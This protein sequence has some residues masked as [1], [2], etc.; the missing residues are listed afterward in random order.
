MARIY[1]DYYK[2]IKSDNGSIV[3]IAIKYDDTFN[4][5]YDVVDRFAKEEPNKLALVHRSAE[6]EDRRFTFGEIKE[7][8]D[9]AANMLKE[10]GVKRGDSVM[11]LLKRR[12]EYWISIIAIHKLGA[13]AIPT[14]HMV[15][16]E[17]IRQRVTLAGAKVVICVNSD[18]ICSKV[19]EALDGINSI[20]LV[21]GDKYKD[22]MSFDEL[23]DEAS[24]KFERV[25]T[26]VDDDMLYYFTSGTS[27]EPKAVI[28][29]FSY[30]IAHIF[31]AKNWHGVEED[32]LHLTVADSGWAKSAWGKLYGQWFMGAAIMVYDY[33]QFYAG[34]MLRLLE[35]EKIRTFCAPPTIYKY[36][37]LEDFSKYNLNNLRYVT[38]AGEPMPKEIAKKFTEL[39]GLTIR[40]GFGQT[41][42]ALQ[43]CTQVGSEQIMGTIGCASP[44]Y[45][46]KLVDEDNNPVPVGEEG[47]IVIVPKDDKRPI[48]IF[49]G[50]LG[51]K[52]LYKEIW[53]GGIYHTKDKAIIDDTGHFYF[54][55]RN[56]D[57]IKSSGYRIG[58][59]EVEDIL[60]RHPAVFECAVTAYPSKNRGAV[61]KASI[62]LNKE[63]SDDGKLSKDIQEFVKNRVA[64]YKYPRIIKF[65][66]ELPRTSTGK[67]SRAKI[68][69]A[70]YQNNR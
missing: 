17:D 64:I 41:E 66:D 21:V 61:V 28:H 23:M 16:A 32:G 25:A 42:T 36:F 33:E 13:V 3:D 65:V 4:F 24:D 34:D 70:D 30:P 39:T 49:K 7:L 27:G 5:A 48:G 62:I 35:R 29:D 67:I 45:D 22:K 8:S 59:S 10:L 55:G 47:E 12:F 53:N 68:R 60:M 31:T 26:H 20:Q 14:S 19:D 52:E 56:D 6:G 58:P 1:Q 51:D 15:S 38:T 54:I 57:V 46:I 63:Y 43:I 2:E 40:E 50:Y 11:L 9:K 18:Q 44:L 69:Q 37:V